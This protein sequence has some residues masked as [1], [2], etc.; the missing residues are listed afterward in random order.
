MKKLVEGG[1]SVSL[2]GLIVMLVISTMSLPVMAEGSRVLVKMKSQETFHVS[3]E[4]LLKKTNLSAKGF[5]FGFKLPENS[6]A[7]LDIEM[8]ADLENLNSLVLND[9]SESELQQ[10][11]ANPDVLFVDQEVIHPL[12]EPQMRPYLNASINAGKNELTSNEK[13]PWGIFAVKAIEAWTLSA[14]GAGSRVLVLDTGIDQNHISLKANFES[15]KN[16]LSDPGQNNPNDFKDLVGHGTHC[17]GT[18]AGVLDSSGFTGVAPQAKLLMGRVCSTQGCSNI[19]IANG[20]N[21]GIS[22]KVDVIS[23]SLGGN[24]STPSERMAI[25]TALK[26]GVTVVAASGN[27]GTNKVS[28]PA[29]LPGVIAVGAV[30]AEL[31]K[32]SFSQYG[33]EISVVAPGVAVVSTVPMG[34]GRESEAKVSVEG[35]SRKVSSTTFGGSE[36]YLD[37]QVSEV[38]FAGLGKPEEFSKVN[39]KGKFALVQRGEI[40][41]IE[42]V[43]NAIDAGAKAI[44]FVN[45]QPGLISGALTDDNSSLGVGVFMIEQTVGD[46]LKLA[47]TKGQKVEISLR[48][49][50]TDYSAFAG[51]SMATPHVAGV[52]ALVK[53]AN[54]KLTPGQV[55]ALLQ[56]TATPL[57]PNEK[58]QFGSGLINAEKAVAEAVKI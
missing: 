5:R 14:S 49:L 35:V 30:D 42:K 50:V 39:V 41:F 7:K 33:P 4:V 45:N 15:G 40:K 19:A 18:I 10:L 53:A 37:S 29:A 3:K 56:R 11:R 34:E 31:K 25:A 32:A 21:W 28:Y 12:L 16:F 54:R 55:K 27:D 57:G 38:V 44:V 48:T 47:L 9:V 22:Q 43:Q 1:R 6:L 20:I 36:E 23:L 26:S 51:T 52:V 24:M 8:E 17:A 46:E 58:N 2:E 13:T